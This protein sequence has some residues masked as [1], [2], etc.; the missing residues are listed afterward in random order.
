M[1]QTVD[2]SGLDRLLK[3][4]EQLLKEFPEAKRQAL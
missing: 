1:A 2:T 3:S 4:W